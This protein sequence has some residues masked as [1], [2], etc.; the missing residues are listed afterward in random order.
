MCLFY[1][2]ESFA[3]MYIYVSG[4]QKGLDTLELAGA[5]ESRESPCGVWD[6]NWVPMQEQA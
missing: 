3:C 1:T 6:L 4:G 5:M 2:Y